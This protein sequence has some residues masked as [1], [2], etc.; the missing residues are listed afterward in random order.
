MPI[1]GHWEFHPTNKILL[2]L[3]VDLL[4]DTHTLKF[5]W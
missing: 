3:A 2:E 1:M 5:E 4:N